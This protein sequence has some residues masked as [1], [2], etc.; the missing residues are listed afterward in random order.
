MKVDTVDKVTWRETGISKLG[1][2]SW[3]F[4]LEGVGS[5]HEAEQEPPQLKDVERHPIA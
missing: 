2:G 4:R 1:H 5:T 3:N